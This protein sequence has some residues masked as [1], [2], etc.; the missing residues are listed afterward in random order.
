M[1]G[2]AVLTRRI[3]GA[4][5]FFL[6]LL[7]SFLAEGPKK[8]ALPDVALGWPLLLHLERAAAA[9]AIVGVVSLVI[10]RAGRGEFPQRIGQIEYATRVVAERMGRVVRAQ[11]W[12]VARIERIL[13]ISSNGVDNP[14]NGG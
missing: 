2:K 7:A 1:A 8:R 4:T 9:T 12:R 3:A 14:E 10:W 13:G 5:V 6:T 11:H